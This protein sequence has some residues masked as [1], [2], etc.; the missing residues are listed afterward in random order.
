M[1]IERLYDN[2]LDHPFN[3]ALADGTLSQEQFQRYMLQDA[4]YLIAFS[5][6][7][8]IASAKAIDPDEMII[9]AQN[10]RN[11]IVVE[12]SLH[13]SFFARF[14]IHDE[15][16][17][18]TEPSPTC[19]NY[20]NFL[21]ATAYHAPY[22]VLVAALLPCFWIYWEVGKAIYQRAQ[23]GNP[24]QDW[25]DTYAGDEFGNIVQEVIAIADRLAEH[26]DPALRKQMLQAF[27]RASQLEWMFWDSAYRLEEWPSL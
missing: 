8:A 24:Y 9:F 19:A 5:R 3:R 14:G 12:R 2:I 10:A 4:Y 25:I 7:L 22:E 6:S 13:A 21:L 1:R 18:A 26:A 17:I 15:A 11:A 23:P 20:T 16:V 27:V